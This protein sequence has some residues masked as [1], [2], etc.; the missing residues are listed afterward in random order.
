MGIHQSNILEPRVPLTVEVGADD[1][2]YFNHK[3]LLPCVCKTFVPIREFATE[4]A[5]THLWIV[6]KRRER[7]TAN[8]YLPTVNF[9][10]AFECPAARILQTYHSKW[11]RPT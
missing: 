8:R 10:F 3:M 6:I 9:A 11:Y 7:C 2:K 1:L 4:D 5:S